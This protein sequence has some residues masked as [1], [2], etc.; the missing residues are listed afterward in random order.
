LAAASRDAVLTEGMPMQ[1]QTSSPR[2][3]HRSRGS[4]RSPEARAL[5]AIVVAWAILFLA[6]VIL[7]SWSTYLLWLLAGTIV[8]GA[9][10]AYDKF[11]AQRGGR[12]IPEMTLMGAS[13]AGG[14][15]GGWFGM[16]ALRH[17]TL[18]KRFWATQWIATAL[19]V[20][21]ALVLLFS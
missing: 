18:H 19:W 1:P 20:A 2:T 7:T 21:I 14:V 8:T 6:G 11:Q 17:K 15:I 12:R 13:L 16:L 3:G 5:I 10:F 9:V 4:K